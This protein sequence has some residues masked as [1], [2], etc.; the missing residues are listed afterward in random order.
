MLTSTRY[1]FVPVP[2]LVKRINLYLRGWAQYFRLGYPRVAFRHVNH[3]ARERL[4][5]HLQRR[6]QRPY[7]P[8]EGRS[9]QDHFTALGLVYL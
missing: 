4:V 1:S 9:W 7:R 3:F 8:P 6:S 2:A 5:C